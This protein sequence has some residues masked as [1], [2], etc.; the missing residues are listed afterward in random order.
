VRSKG[1]SR[2]QFIT[3]LLQQ[4]VGGLQ[5]LNPDHEW[6]DVPPTPGAFVIN[7][8]EMLQE[9][10]GNYVVAATHSGAGVYGQQLWNY[11]ARSYPENMARHRSDA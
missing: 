8:G 11:Y 2:R 3:V 9:M 6:I 1:A 10:T 7:L 4:D 5:A